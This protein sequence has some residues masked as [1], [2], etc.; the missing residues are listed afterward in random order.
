[1]V[2]PKSFAVLGAGSYGTAL[3]IL[4]ASNGHNVTLWA[5]NS[6]QV[7]NMQQERT[8]THYLP[9]VAFPPSLTA[10]DNIS[11]AVTT[12]DVVLVAVPSL[13]CLTFVVQV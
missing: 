9:D 8:N 5:R 6:A 3:A 10:T 2:D 1:M 11:E 4:L 13:G 7:E 12:A